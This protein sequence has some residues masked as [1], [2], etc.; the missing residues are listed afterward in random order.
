MV[1]EFPILAEYGI[2]MLEG[3]L[4][5]ATHGHKFLPANLPLQTGDLYLQG[6]THVP[7]CR[8]QNGVLCLN[9]GSVSIPKE[10]S[11]HQYMTY[12]KGIFQ[13]KDFSGSILNTCRLDSRESRTKTARIAGTQ[14]LI[15]PEE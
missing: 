6:H 5:Y 2:L 9:P 14:N 10:N 12:E 11:H 1:L 3:H 8:E 7:V 13:W 15:K 4:L